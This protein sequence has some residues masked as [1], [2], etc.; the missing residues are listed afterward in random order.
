M[1]HRFH[2][3]AAIEVEAAVF[4]RGSFAAL[5]QTRDL[6]LGGAFVQTGPL[7]FCRHTPLEIELAL[8]GEESLGPLR[9]PAFVVHSHPQGAGLMFLNIDAENRAAIRRVLRS[10]DD[11][12][13]QRACAERLP[14][15]LLAGG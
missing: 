4:H 9:L 10:V 8:P 5:G 14:N 2:Q 15:V 7:S 6:S 11:G 12:P 1:E 13:A 3:R